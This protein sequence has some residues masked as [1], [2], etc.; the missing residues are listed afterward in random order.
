MDRFID[1]T[2]GAVADQAASPQSLLWRRVKDD[3][4]LWKTAMK[5]AAVEPAEREVVIKRVPRQQLQAIRQRERVACLAH[6]R[7]RLQSSCC[8]WR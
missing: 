2:L 4:E 3:T 8:C 6:K 5:N 1:A 7:R